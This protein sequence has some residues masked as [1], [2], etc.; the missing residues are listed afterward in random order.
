M[1]RVIV[2]PFAVADQ[3]EILRYLAREAGFAIAEKYDA[4]FRALLSRLSDFPG[5]GAPR[6]VL[7]ASI[8]I[9]VINPYVVIYEG[10]TG[11]PGRIAQPAP[12]PTSPAHVERADVLAAPARADPV[13]PAVPA[14]GGRPRAPADAAARVAAALDRNPQPARFR[15]GWRNRGR[16]GQDSSQRR[17]REQARQREGQDD[18]ACH[19]ALPSSRRTARPA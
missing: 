10:T 17:H 5:I 18:A 14:A 7:G 9:Y 6:P 15:A 19:C 11:C 4:A 8:R 1:A 3:D 13:A 12:R 16:P 2:S